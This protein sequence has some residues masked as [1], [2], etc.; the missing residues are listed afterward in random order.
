MGRLVF[1]H[2]YYFH[3]WALLRMHTAGSDIGK[4]I[5]YCWSAGWEGGEGEG[6]RVHRERCR[7]KNGNRGSDK[8][9]CKYRF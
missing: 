5:I 1:T 7:G 6:D 4:A 3:L 8:F 9:M 2:S